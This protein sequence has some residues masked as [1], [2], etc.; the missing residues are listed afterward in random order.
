LTD[1]S[2]EIDH[3]LRRLFPLC[4][5]ITGH[6]NRETLRILQ[7]IIP[8]SILEIPTGEKVYDWEIPREWNVREAW[9]KNSRGEKIVDFRNNN[10]H[11]VSYSQPVHT[12]LGW[13]DLKDHLHYREGLPHAIPYKTS[14]YRE[15]WGFCIS[16]DD[17]RRL[18]P[19]DEEFEVFIDSEL[20]QGNL[21]LGEMLIPGKSRREYLISTYFCH[22]SLANDNLSGVVLTAFLAREL[23]K[24]PRQFSYRVVFAPE[25]IGAIAYCQTHEE[26]MKKILGGFVV[27]CVG[28]P[29]S[30][31]FKKSFDP[32]HWINAV[33][34]DVL[35]ETGEEFLVYPF[36]HG[37]DERQY[38]SPAFRINMVTVGKD[39]YFEYPGYHT[40]LDNLDLVKAGAIHQSLG[41][42]LKVLD[43]LDLEIIFENFNPAC[44]TMLSRHGLYPRNDEDLVFSKGKGLNEIHIILW[45]LFYCDGKTGL[46]EISRKMEVPVE[47]LGRVAEKL[48][49]AKVLGRV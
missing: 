46:N 5:S 34:E 1:L 47:A 32:G 44:E 15:T 35:R 38:S 45:L 4:R 29:G 20:T 16:W 6:G 40:S 23:M 9:I 10:L 31:Y 42:Y 11:L 2:E 18:F 22:P 33:V 19:G 48:E 21:T 39:K 24:T 14:Y 49:K 41:I 30:V 7:E 17:C 43:R 13:N 8:L 27:T 25:T 3:Y 36:D 37:S 28:G 12:R 26:A